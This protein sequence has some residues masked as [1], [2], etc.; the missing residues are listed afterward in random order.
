MIVPYQF[1]KAFRSE[2]GNKIHKNKLSPCQASLLVFS[3]YPNNP[4]RAN[5]A[6]N[7]YNSGVWSAEP[8]DPSKPKKPKKPS[9]LSFM[10]ASLYFKRI[11]KKRFFDLF[12]AEFNS[13]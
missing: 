13:N 3:L 6:Y 10:K 8:S 5:I 2:D 4:N 9:M 12:N 11:F 7:P 1:P